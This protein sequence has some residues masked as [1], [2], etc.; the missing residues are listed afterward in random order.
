M[1]KASEKLDFERAAFYRDR[2][3]LIAKIQS[4]QN[5]NNLNVE[6]AD[7]IGLFRLGNEVCIQVFFIRSYENRGNHAFFPKTGGGAEDIEI[8]ENFLAQFY[9]TKIPAREILYRIL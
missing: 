8:I 3:E 2:I 4:S 9:S 5:I 6:D 1:L 7:V